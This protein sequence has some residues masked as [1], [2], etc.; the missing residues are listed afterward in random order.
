MNQSPYFANKKK[1]SPKPKPKTPMVAVAKKN[2][3]IAKNNPCLPQINTC[4]NKD[5]S[6]DDDDDD[7]NTKD[8]NNVNTACTEN[9]N[10][11]NNNNNKMR[12]DLLL[13]LRPFQREAYEFA[14]QGKTTPR[15]W[16]DETKQDDFQ[17]DP[18]LLGKGRILLAGEQ[19]L[20]V[21]WLVDGSLY[22][23]LGTSLGYI[24]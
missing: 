20:N 17:Y 5:G 1:E 12:D 3:K 8:D 18:A 24:Q 22:C 2:E 14:T 13:K 15:Q 10:N 23:S 11:N 21:F 9:N 7:D 6:D 4:S 16:N 19:E